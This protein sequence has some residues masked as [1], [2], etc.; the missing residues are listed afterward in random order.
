MRR[1]RPSWPR[2]RKRKCSSREASGAAPEQYRH[3]IG[4][5]AVINAVPAIAN[6]SHPSM[7]RL[8]KPGPRGTSPRVGF[9]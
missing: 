8:I 7:T 1:A 2:C 3:F 5:T 6:L 9:A 4:P